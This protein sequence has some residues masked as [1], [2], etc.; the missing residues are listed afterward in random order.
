MGDRALEAAV[1]QLANGG[2]WLAL[3]QAAGLIHLEPDPAGGETWTQVRWDDVRTVL[4]AGPLVGADDRDWLL[5]ASRTV[6]R[7]TCAT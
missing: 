1:L 4:Q 7:S 6:S 3:L 5:G 2:H